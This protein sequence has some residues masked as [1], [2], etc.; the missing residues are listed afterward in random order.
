MERVFRIELKSLGWK[1]KI[2]PLYDTRWN[3]YF[4]SSNI[5]SSRTNSFSIGL[6]LSSVLGDMF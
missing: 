2:I 6:P 1:P 4:N 3:Y 5:Q